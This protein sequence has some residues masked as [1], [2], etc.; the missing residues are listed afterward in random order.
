M[1]NLDGASGKT[2]FNSSVATLE[3]VNDALRRAAHYKSINFL[4]AWSYALD[5]CKMETYP[6]MKDKEKEQCDILYSD[7]E[8]VRNLF[9]TA[10][11]NNKHILQRNLRSKLNSYELFLR[12]IMDQ[13]GMLLSDMRRLRGL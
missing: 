4:I 5:D 2:E 1:V 8:N 10:K 7:L 11:V 3:R 13:R 9:E 12:S 6:K